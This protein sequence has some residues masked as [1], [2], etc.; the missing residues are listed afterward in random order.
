MSVDNKANIFGNSYKERKAKIKR[1]FPK[2]D[3]PLPTDLYSLIIMFNE[4]VY[5]KAWNQADDIHENAF[6]EELHLKHDLKTLHQYHNHAVNIQKLINELCNIYHSY[7][8]PHDWSASAY[9]DA[10]SR[11]DDYMTEW[12]KVDSVFFF[13]L[14]NKVRPLTVA[15]MRI[16]VLLSGTSLSQEH[17]IVS[18]KL[19]LGNKVFDLTAE[20]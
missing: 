10:Q 4:D 20:S 12:L 5:K 17:N 19:T 13:F 1:Y 15:F 14:S 3:P 2:F 8:N 7:D 16:L 9:N 11:L 6:H 18:A